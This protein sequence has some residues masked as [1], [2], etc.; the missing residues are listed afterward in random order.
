VQGDGIPSYMKGYYIADFSPTA[1]PDKYRTATYRLKDN[2]GFI[3]VLISGTGISGSFA[4][5]DG[6]TN[7]RIGNT[8]GDLY[9]DQEMEHLSFL[10]LLIRL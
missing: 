7:E 9:I 8:R 10:L 2:A 4:L 5:Y 6:K 1:T 3:Q